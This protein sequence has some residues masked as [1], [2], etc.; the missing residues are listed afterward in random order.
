MKN[1]VDTAKL[2]LTNPHA[3]V[4]GAS[5][6]V[7]NRMMDYA[8]SEVTFRLEDPETLALFILL[9]EKAE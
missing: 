9:L 3:A 1:F 5:G 7:W 2:A 6:Q 4:L 8:G